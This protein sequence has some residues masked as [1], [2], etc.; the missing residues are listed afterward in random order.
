MMPRSLL[1][2]SASILTFNPLFVIVYV[3]PIHFNEVT[4]AALNMSDLLEDD[5]SLGELGFDLYDMDDITM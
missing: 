2:R 5:A 4:Q 1:I 3:A